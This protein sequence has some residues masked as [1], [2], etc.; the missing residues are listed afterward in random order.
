MSSRERERE[1]ESYS[2]GDYTVPGVRL[3]EA[4]TCK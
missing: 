3:R 4:T 1:R 2:I